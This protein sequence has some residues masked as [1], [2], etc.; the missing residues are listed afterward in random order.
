MLRSAFA[1]PSF[2]NDSAVEDSILTRIAHLPVTGVGMRSKDQGAVSERDLRYEDQQRYE[3]A[4]VAGKPGIG[5]GFLGRGP[6]REQRRRDSIIHQGNL[7]RLAKLAERA[8][9]AK[10]QRDSARK[11]D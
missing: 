1:P 5:V 11:P 8:A 6:S 9:L 3:P 2:S 7:Q 10:A 4:H